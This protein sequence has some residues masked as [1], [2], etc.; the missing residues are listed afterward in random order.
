MKSE[1]VIDLPEKVFVEHVLPKSVEI[2]LYSKERIKNELILSYLNKQNVLDVN[3]LNSYN[4]KD[5]QSLNPFYRN[6]DYPS[7]KWIADTTGTLWLRARE[8]SIGFQGNAEEY[9]WYH[10]NRLDKLEEFLENNPD[11]YLIFYN[12]T[13]ELFE[14]FDICEKLGYKI[15]V[16]TGEIKYM[17]NYNVYMSQNE[18]E[19]MNNTKNVIIANFAS[20]STGMNWQGYNK[21][22]IFSLPLYKDYEQGIKRIHRIGQNKTTIYH[23]F[24]E[25]NWLDNS[26]LKALKEQID[27]STK[28]FET[29]FKKQSILDEIEEN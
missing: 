12:Y 26:M 18:S 19:Q 2:D 24:Y 15:D 3:I 27:Y 1:D 9:K 16:Y 17:N 28:M 14:I 8:L 20:G 10:R 7:T 21:C 23:M 11:N 6:I 29:D 25:D 22:I 4:K 13:P 5:T